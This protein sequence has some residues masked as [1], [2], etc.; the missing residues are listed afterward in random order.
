LDEAFAED[1]R[2]PIFLNVFDHQFHTAGVADE[3]FIARIV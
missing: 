2:T 3:G 1:G